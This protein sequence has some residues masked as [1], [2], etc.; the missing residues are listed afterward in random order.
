MQNELKELKEFKGAIN[1][2]EEK[3]AS[4]AT[5]ATQNIKTYFNKMIKNLLTAQ[6][7]IIFKEN[8]IKKLEGD[9]VLLNNKLSEG[10]LFF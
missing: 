8:L 9:V 3:D 6:N 2:N 7:L 10:K 4:N 1:L 5:G